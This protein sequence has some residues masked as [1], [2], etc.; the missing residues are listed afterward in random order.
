MIDCRCYDDSDITEAIK[1]WDTTQYGW[2]IVLAKEI[3]K[4]CKL[5]GLNFDDVYREP[6]I[7]YNDGY[8]SLDMDYVV[9]PWLKDMPGPIGGHCVIPNC[10]ILVK[11]DPMCLV[12]TTILLV[13]DELKRE[14]E[15][16][17]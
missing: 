7:N 13:N 14:T 8:K 16:S 2:Q 1:L 11:A 10:E 4:W 17:K 9:R 15:N 3:S 6:N 12:P 5:H